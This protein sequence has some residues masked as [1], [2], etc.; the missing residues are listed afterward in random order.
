[1]DGVLTLMY[2]SVDGNDVIEIEEELLS[3]EQ[4]R[5]INSVI[6]VNG[7]LYELVDKKIEGDMVFVLEENTYDS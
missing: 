7:K 3:E 6:K 5:Y 1:M 2:K 4:L